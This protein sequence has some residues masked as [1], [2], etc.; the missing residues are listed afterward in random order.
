MLESSENLPLKCYFM[1]PSCVP[2]TF[3]ETAG[4]VLEAEDLEELIN[5]ERILGLGE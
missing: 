4:A 3:F 2:A 1:L 5:H